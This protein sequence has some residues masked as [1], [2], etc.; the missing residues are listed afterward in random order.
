MIKITVVSLLCLTEN[1]PFFIIKK[2]ADKKYNCLIGN[3]FEACYKGIHYIIV[4]RK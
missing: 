2:S 3:Q 1:K 4:A